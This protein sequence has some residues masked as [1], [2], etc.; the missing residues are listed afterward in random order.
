MKGIYRKIE[1]KIDVQVL[2]LN[3]M[4]KIK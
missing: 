4:N 3:E 2:K 1:I